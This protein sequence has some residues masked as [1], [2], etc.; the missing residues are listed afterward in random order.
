MSAQPQELWR[1]VPMSAGHLPSV[2]DIEK[3]SYAFPW[4][5]GNFR[6][7]LNAGYSCWVVESSF[8]DVMG[9]ALMSMAAGEAHILN[10]CIAP[11]YQ[12]QGMGRNL[13]LH[14]IARAW[15]MHTKLLLLEV[16]RSN[17]AAQALYLAQ[18]FKP[19]GVRR[20][21]YPAQGGRED[22]IVLGLELEPES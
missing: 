2:L 18:G 21:Y 6:D 15:E 17:A 22:A 10:L 5:E 3:R 11:E 14:L 8:M 20:D 7:S 9:Y 4:T 16:R 13:L 19:L 1:L 12:G